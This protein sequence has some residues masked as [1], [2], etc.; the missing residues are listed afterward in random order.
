MIACGTRADTARAGQITGY[1]SAECRR[2][3]R[4]SE[5]RPE[6]RRLERELLAILGEPGLDIGDRRPGTSGQRQLGRLVPADTGQGARL[7]ARRQVSGPPE[8]TFAGGPHNVK[9]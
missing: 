1:G 3:R 6:I 7:D 4:R 5:E 9:R 8:R 2:H